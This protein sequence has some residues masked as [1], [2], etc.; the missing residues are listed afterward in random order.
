MH[1]V[2]I[3]L[4]NLIY[5]KFNY[6]MWLFCSKRWKFLI[7]Q[8]TKL[9]AVLIQMDHHKI[10]RASLSNLSNVFITWNFNYFSIFVFLCFWDEL[11]LSFVH[12]ISHELIVK[13][14]VVFKLL[15]LVHVFSVKPIFEF[16]FFIILFFSFS[17]YL[18]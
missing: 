7:D 3:I 16:V 14:K 11:S 13:I 9:I 6:Y 5:D 12:I 15:Q 1:L 10:I 8:I 18:S 4:I 2:E 17:L